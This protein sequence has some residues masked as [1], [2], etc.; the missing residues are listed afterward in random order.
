[1]EE[2]KKIDSEINFL[3]VLKNP[4]RL[5]GLVY[6]YFFIVALAI[7]IY[8]VHNLDSITFNKVPGSAIDTL[9]I[10]REIETKIGGIK[11]AM[12]LSLIT[13]PTPEL[14]EEGKQ[15]YKTNCASCHGDNGLGDGL[16]SAAL[17]PKPR[18][19]TDANGWKN[20]STFYGMYKTLNEGITGSG[21]V[22]YEFIPPQDRVA[23]IHY[24]RTFA[25]YPEITQQEVDEKLEPE[26]QL[27]AGIIDP[28]NIPIKKSIS[29]YS[30][31]YS[32]KEELVISI[33]AVI[34]NDISDSA[35]LLKNNSVDLNR[36]VSKFISSEMKKSFQI[37][38]DGISLDPYSVGL[39]NS[40][41]LL[42]ESKLRSVYNYLNS[43]C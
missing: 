14:V 27:S 5:F 31:E 23:M 41:L 19:F 16:A 37:F 40:M 34:Q 39:K 15:L 10:E 30:N 13:N 6:I 26:Y 9:N 25:D 36:T 18:N 43:I 22:A 32:K 38:L 29:I 42:D 33:V 11:P 7:G 1:M 4:L 28:N 8:Y 20:G 21:M 35:E 17:N 2:K 3:S 12:D 24:I